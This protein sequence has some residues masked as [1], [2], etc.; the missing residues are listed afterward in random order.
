M[1]ARGALDG[2]NHDRNSLDF[3]FLVDVCSDFAV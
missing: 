2:Y 3:K 1:S